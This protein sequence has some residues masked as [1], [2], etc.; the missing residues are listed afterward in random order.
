SQERSARPPASGE[1]PSRDGSG[2]HH[3]EPPGK[4]QH[5]EFP[6]REGSGVGTGTQGAT[7]DR[8][9]LSLSPH[10]AGGEGEMPAGASIVFRVTDTGIG[11]TPEQMGK[12]FRA[13]SQADGSTTRRFG[14]TGLGLALTKKFCQIMGGDVRVASEP[15]KGSTFTIELPAIAP[16]QPGTLTVTPA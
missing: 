15:G 13:F 14:G 3:G 6:S 7:W 11:M 9:N 4:L 5:G 10:T 2:V 12:L 1:F 16:K 8:G